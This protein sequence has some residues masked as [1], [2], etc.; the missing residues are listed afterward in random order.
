MRAP[1]PRTSSDARDTVRRPAR[2]LS[3]QRPPPG[4][5][6]RARKRPNDRVRRAANTRLSRGPV[7][8]SEARPA[9]GRRPFRI[10]IVAVHGRLAVTPKAFVLSCAEIRPAG[11]AETVLAIARMP[12]K[13]AATRSIDTVTPQARAR[14]QLDTDP[15]RRTSVSLRRVRSW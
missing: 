5:T 13:T 7:A 12:S 4:K 10:E 6:T 3:I 1:A 14:F 2:T 9:N 11:A 8:M 15:A